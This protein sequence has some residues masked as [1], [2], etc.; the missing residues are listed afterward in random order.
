MELPSLPV[1]LA[2]FVPYLGKQTRPDILNETALK[3]FHLYESK[4]R[5]IFAQEPENKVVADP[6]INVV[7]VYTG[8]EGQL[9]VKPRDLEKESPAE[10]DKYILPLST[11]FRRDQGSPA[12]VPSLREFKDNFRLFSESSLVDL[13]WSNVVVAGSAVTTCLLPLSGQVK[14]SRRA[15]REFYHEK[16]APASDVDLFIYGLNEEQAIAKIKQ[17][18][19]SIRNSILEETTVIRTKNALTIVS[20]YPT[21]HVQIVLRLYKSVSE[22]LTGFDVDCSCTAFDGSQV[23]MSPR[24]LASFV[25]QANT[26]DLTRR[27]PS[28]ENRLAKYS[29]RG[30]EVYW[31]KLDRSKVDPTILE[32]SFTHVVGL[33]RLLVMEKLPT[34]SARDSYVDQRRAERD[35]PPSTKEKFY[36]NPHGNLKEYQP[37]DVAEWVEDEDVSNYHTF[38]IPYGPKYTAKKIERLFYKKDLLLNAEWN[39]SKER[40]VNLHRHPAFFG[41]VEH[42]IED[43]CGFCPSPATEEEIQVAEEESKRF[44]SGKIQFMKDDPGRQAIGSFNPI[45][46]TDWTEMAYLGDNVRICQAIVDKDLE[47][48]KSCCAQEGFKIDKRD[49]TGRMP[50]HL[51]VMCSTPEIVQCLVDSGSRLVARVAGGYT[52]LHLAAARG[53]PEILRIILKKSEANKSEHLEK[54]E[55]KLAD[56]E[57]QPSSGDKHELESQDP[58]DDDISI[59]QSLTDGAYAA[60]QGS[61][62]VVNKSNPEME[63][64]PEETDDEGDEPNFYDDVNVVSWDTPINPLQLAVLYGHAEI[65][66]ILATEFGAN[67]SLPII[68]RKENHHAYHDVTLSMALATYHPLEKSKQVLRTMLELGASC[69][70][71][72]M[73]HITAFHSIVMEGEAALIDLLFELDGPAAQLAIN[74]PA[75][76]PHYEPEARMPLFTAVK[77][78]GLPMIEKLLEHGASV[79]GPS[80]RLRRF[81][82]RRESTKANIVENFL[83]QPIIAAAQFGSPAIIKALL[84]AGSDPNAMT[85]ASYAVLSSRYSSDGGQTVLDIIARRIA[86]LRNPTRQDS[87]TKSIS[88]KAPVLKPDADYLKGL[89][90]GSYEYYFVQNELE[91]AKAAVQ[92][93]EERRKRDLKQED[94]KQQKEQ[95]K[96]KWAEAEL[97][98]LEG[99]EAILLEKGAKPFHKL[100]PGFKEKSTRQVH[101]PSR[102]SYP[103]EKPSEKEFSISHIFRD[104][105]VGEL[106]DPGYMQLFEA[107]WEGDIQKVKS[108]TLGSWDADEKKL[109]LRITAKNKRN[110]DPFTIAVSRGHFDLAKVILDIVEAQYTPKTTVPARKVY[111]IVVD[112]AEDEYSESESESGSQPESEKEDDHGISVRFNL[113]D[114]QHTIDDIRELTSIVKS[115]TPPWAV[116]TNFNVDMAFFFDTARKKDAFTERIKNGYDS[117]IQSYV[118]GK[119]HLTGVG[120]LEKLCSLPNYNSN[121]LLF[122]YAVEKNDLDAVKFMVEQK[123]N[124]HDAKDEAGPP[125]LHI[126]TA[127]FKIAIERGYTD[128]L[129]Y[130]ISKTG[131]QFPFQSLMKKAGAK[132]DSKPESYQ[133]LTVYG[134][135]REDWAAEDGEQWNHGFKDEDNLLLRAAFSTNL[136]S[137]KWFLS[138]IPEQKYK[139]FAAAYADDKHVKSFETV[140]GGFEGVLSSWLHSRRDLALHCAVLGNSTKET[141]VAHV[142]MILDA[143]PSSLNAKNKAGITALHAAFA[144]QKIMAARALVKRGADQTLRDNQGRNMLHYILSPNKSGSKA[145]LQSSRLFKALSSVLDKEVLRSLAIQRSRVQP[146]RTYSSWG[147][148]TPLAEWLEG[149]GDPEPDMLRTIL[150]ATGGQELYVLDDKGSYP[151]HQAVRRNLISIVRVMLEMDPKLA[152]LE[153]ATGVTPLEL[154]ENK[155]FEV[156]LSSLKQG[157]RKIEGGDSAELWNGTPRIYESLYEDDRYRYAQRRPPPEEVHKR[158]K[159]D[160][161]RFASSD[162]VEYK[163]YRLLQEVAGD[164]KAQRKLISL[165]DANQLVKRLAGRKWKKAAEEDGENDANKND[166]VGRFLYSRTA[167]WEVDEILEQEKK[168]KKEKEK[169]KEG[170]G[171][172]DSEMP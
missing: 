10:S 164:S 115:S 128:M 7:P 32:R 69:T 133:G 13:D 50:I 55:N 35:R 155:L 163:L 43:C 85:R 66:D 98:S 105:D 104:H 89:V 118:Y 147:M 87:Q 99:I 28:Y 157:T 22:I 60:T 122:N 2:E 16:I 134:R 162:R 84:D 40:T 170:Q 111:K 150:E 72:D 93:I 148:Q 91:L 123:S 158:E 56:A 25:T 27:S 160:K 48:V 52:V 42:V 120:F 79:S 57:E 141:G 86:Y 47:T 106:S 136:D 59:V 17:I 58:E 77:E 61:M 82:A 31:P 121:N 113:V 63:N 116:I 149:A 145:V 62:V 97:K 44:I 38:T 126:T 14:S 68:W 117:S 167:N 169:G 81:W 12:V 24:A 95:A 129:D 23:W 161:P 103:E 125:F 33:A 146:G 100:H 168:E 140:P 78:K 151:I 54:S 46:D 29:H 165:Q 45:T 34:A 18:E 110:I 76:L 153:N 92:V 8:H 131:T 108:L 143:V 51:A 19:T 26:I 9:K 154:A 166:E 74:H 138:D 30:F 90:E 49:H 130:L 159:E 152:L 101:Q 107:A 109:P 70:Q 71:A 124:Y 142:E 94:E 3:P 65:V 102:S 1:P 5:E 64:P 119:E 21:R 36:R 80:E 88:P 37:E 127:I 112:A 171:N 6:H 67:V 96:S 172:K 156:V 53:D 73:K 139:E 4:L 75:I 135:K 132:L 39:K 137:I 114:Q 41:A 83:I 15:Q 20:K 11:A 144:G